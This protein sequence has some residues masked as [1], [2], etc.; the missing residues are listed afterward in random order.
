MKRRW[1][2]IVSSFLILSAIALGLWLANKNIPYLG[3][4]IVEM[5]FSHDQPMISRLGPEV[6]IKSEADCWL[7]LESPV[8]F[9]LRTLPWFKEARIYLTFTNGS[10]ELEGIGYQTGSAWQ[11]EVKAPLTI[12][13]IDDNWQKA[14][15]DFNLKDIYQQKNVRRFLISLK[16]VNQTNGGNE[17]GFKIKDLKVILSR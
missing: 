8:Y 17:G 10:L 16:P 13:P 11:Y 1:L 4:L 3:N 12:T 9:D 6:R 7:I 15:F 5:N 2:K 14:V